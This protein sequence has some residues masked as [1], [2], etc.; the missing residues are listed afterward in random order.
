MVAAGNLADVVGVLAAVAARGLTVSLQLHLAE[1]PQEQHRGRQGRDEDV[2]QPLRII[3]TDGG[4]GGSLAKQGVRVSRPRQD[5]GCPRRVRSR[6]LDNPACFWLHL[7]DVP[8]PPAGDQHRAVCDL[9]D[10]D[11]A[12]PERARGVS[13]VALVAAGHVTEAVEVASVPAL[14]EVWAVLRPKPLVAAV[15]ERRVVEDDKRVLADINPQRPRA[16]IIGIL[17]QLER[18]RGEAGQ[19]P[20]HSAQVSEVVD[21]TVTWGARGGGIDRR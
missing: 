10:G 11:E 6:I 3:W 5:E 7:I 13:T 17:Q 20:Q 18:K 15:R 21:A 8:A 16:R 9:I 19:V 1:V 2:E 14:G 12:D 4:A